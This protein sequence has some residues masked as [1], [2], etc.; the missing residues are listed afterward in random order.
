MKARVERFWPRCEWHKNGYC[1]EIATHATVL[2]DL[3][4]FGKYCKAHADVIVDA[5]NGDRPKA[6]PSSESSG[7]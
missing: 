4:P 1:N 7:T 5:V 3:G 6:V 2:G